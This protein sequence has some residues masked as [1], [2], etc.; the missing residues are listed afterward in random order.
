MPQSGSTTA[1][2]FGG[3]GSMLGHYAWFNKNAEDHLWPVG[4]RAPNAWGFFDLYGNT[5]EWCQN[6]V[7]NIPEEAAMPL[8][9][10]DQ[11]AGEGSQPRFVRGG[12]YRYTIRE[13]RSAKRFDVLPEAQLSFLGLS[14]IPEL[15]LTDGGLFD[16]D[17][18][19]YVPV[20]ADLETVSKA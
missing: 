2:S 1:W 16:V 3:D 13:V 7:M 20:E 12:G 9:R 18:F 17:A 15:R 6:P 8:I 4:L 10:D 5:L 14:V 11:F 19:A